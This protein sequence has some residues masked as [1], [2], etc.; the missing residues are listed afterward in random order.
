MISKCF[1][2]NKN[3]KSI[4]NEKQLGVW[5]NETTTWI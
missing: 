2:V 3:I 1:I 4:E 5:H